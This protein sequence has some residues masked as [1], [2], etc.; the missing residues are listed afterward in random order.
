MTM[1]FGRAH[2]KYSNPIQRF[3]IY[4]QEKKNVNIQF[5]TRD[6]QRHFSLPSDRKS[7]FTFAGFENLDDV[8]D[9]LD[10]SRFMNVPIDK[11]VHF[12]NFTE[13]ELENR[14]YPEFYIYFTE[15]KPPNQ[16]SELVGDDQSNIRIFGIENVYHVQRNYI[17]DDY[18][19]P[20]TFLGFYT[21]GD[22]RNALENRNLSQKAENQELFYFSFTENDLRIDDFNYRPSLAYFYFKESSP[23]GK[24]L[25][26]YY[27]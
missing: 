8:Q 17:F 23:P 9:A 5:K 4:F 25:R 14:I 16:P 7:V 11:T 12:F 19:G 18:T 24:S 1:I 15:I 20:Y 21:I 3:Y 2:S 13:E 6:I 27:S 22:L 26:F 10:N